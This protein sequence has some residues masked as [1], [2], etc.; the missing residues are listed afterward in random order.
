M[1]AAPELFPEMGE[2]FERYAGASPLQPL[3]DLADA[4]VWPVGGQEVM[5]A[6]TRAARTPVD[7]ANARGWRDHPRRGKGAG[8]RGHTLA[9][10]PGARGTMP[11]RTGRRIR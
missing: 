4:L 7:T 10:H 11:I 5:C 9:T 2:L 1:A 8:T 3:D 6:R